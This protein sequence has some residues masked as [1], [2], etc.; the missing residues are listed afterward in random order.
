[1]EKAPTR[2]PPLLSWQGLVSTVKSARRI[3]KYKS[4]LEKIQQQETQGRVLRHNA[5]MPFTV[6]EANSPYAA[7]SLS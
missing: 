3:K 6:K 2:E 5:V 7:C 4:I 1:M